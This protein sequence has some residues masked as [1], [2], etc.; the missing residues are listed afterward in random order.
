MYGQP[1]TI[2][3]NLDMFKWISF[4]NKKR[5]MNEGNKSMPIYLMSGSKDPLSNYGKDIKTLYETM[6]SLGYQNVSMKLYPDC[7]HESLNELIKDEVYQDILKF[8]ET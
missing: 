1:F 2:Q 4:V 3:A 5:N 8:I 6:K 7:R